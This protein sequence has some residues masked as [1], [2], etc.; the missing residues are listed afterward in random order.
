MKLDQTFPDLKSLLDMTRLMTKKQTIMGKMLAMWVLV[1][2]LGLLPRESVWIKGEEVVPEEERLPGSPYRIFDLYPIRFFI[3]P[4]SIRLPQTGETTCVLTFLPG[5]FDINIH[6][7]R[8]FPDCF[9][10]LNYSLTLLG[11]DFLKGFLATWR[12]PGQYYGHRA[13][14][15]I[16]DAA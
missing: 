10:P 15:A 14:T 8:V 3:D 6:Q 7:L 2:A 12:M 13:D 16:G 1:Y 5:A 4:I 11:G 9:P